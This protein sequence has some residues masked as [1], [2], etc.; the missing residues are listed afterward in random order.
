MKS[1]IKKILVEQTRCS[2]NWAKNLKYWGK[3]SGWRKGMI[4]TINKALRDV[5][6]DMWERPTKK[7]MSSG[8]VVGYEVAQ[9]S[10]FGWSILNF[11]NAHR[12]VREALI[13][14]Y[15]L[16]L[17]K[18]GLECEFKIKDFLNWVSNE[19]YI[20]FGKDTPMVKKLADLNHNTWNR[21][22]KNEGEAVEYLTTLYGDD[23]GAEWSGE[24]GMF[25]DALTGVDIIMINKNSGEEHGYQAKPLVDAVMLDDNKWK[26]QSRGLYPYPTK[27]VNYYIF[28]TSGRDGVM[29]FRNKGEKPTI[30]NGREYMVFDTA[31]IAQTI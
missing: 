23:W 16:W 20:L 6:S 3:N 19:R 4:Q 21:G 9:G 26:I 22:S 7:H 30:E 5:Y 24:P 27:T 10:T 11:F 18:E 17:S 31:P 1:L 13:D 29:I 12:N 15:G 28:N 2:L 8:G 14:E 25:S